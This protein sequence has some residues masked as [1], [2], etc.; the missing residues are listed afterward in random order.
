MQTIIRLRQ[1][2]SV[3]MLALGL[4]QGALAQP[5]AE[6]PMEHPVSAP[7]FYQERTFWVLA[8]LVIAGT[9]FIAFRV[10]RGRW[11]VTSEPVEF[12]NEAVLVVDLADSTHLATH[13][14]NGLAMQA[15]NILKERTLAA[16]QANGLKFAESTGDG[17][18]MSFPSVVGAV[19]TATA[20]LKD[21]RNRP[22]EFTSGPPLAV[23]V[24]ISYGEILL[25][26][27]DAR[28]GATI[29]KAFRLE[30]LSR[31]SFSSPAGDSEPKE[32]PDRNRI[33][34]DEE[35]AKELHGDTVPLR[36][37]GFCSLKGFSGL[38]RV[39]EVLGAS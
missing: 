19:Q 39:Y 21:L 4:A 3:V 12:I 29:N 22:S 8:G 24:G 23:R 17:Y 26:S 11:R 2:L 33:F 13:Y 38:H 32:I 5:S 34:L 9:G 27:S 20:L 37:V 10:V 30:G 28:H 36:F 1:L 15:R 7:P 31:A 25:D 18:F 14:G 6:H 35:A 16:A